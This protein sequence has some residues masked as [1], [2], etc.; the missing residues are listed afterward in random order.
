M[1]LT[2]SGADINTSDT[3]TDTSIRENPQYDT[4]RSQHKPAGNEKLSRA[5]TRVL[6]HVDL[7]ELELAKD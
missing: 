1:L 5:I 6:T 7:I 4:A 3:G 2:S